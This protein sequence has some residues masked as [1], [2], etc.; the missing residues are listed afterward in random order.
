MILPTLAYHFWQIT[1]LS[2]KV[3]GLATLISLLI[4][5]PFG[6]LLALSKF[7]GRSVLLTLVNT[8]M[9]LPPVAVIWRVVAG[10]CAGADS[11]LADSPKIVHAVVKAINPTR[12]NRH[13]NEFRL[14]HFFILSPKRR[15]ALLPKVLYPRLRPA[16]IVSYCEVWTCEGKPSALR[17]PLGWAFRR[18]LR[19][20][21]PVPVA[22]LRSALHVASWGRKIGCA[23]SETTK[24]HVT[25]ISPESSL[26]VILHQIE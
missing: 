16:K 19:A 26:S 12:I 9:A 13:P 17:A 25:R 23:S 20:L 2:I 3:S 14:R 24:G 22:A 10:A 18:A 4:G 7:P 15:S 8:G 6:T 11:G 5:L 1:L 21:A